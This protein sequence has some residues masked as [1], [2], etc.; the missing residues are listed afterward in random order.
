[1]NTVIFILKKTT[2]I[3]PF[4]SMQYSQQQKTHLDLGQYVSILQAYWCI[5]I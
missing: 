5:K 4:Y 3:V 1:M 2:L